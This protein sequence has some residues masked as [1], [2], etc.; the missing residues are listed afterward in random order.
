MDIRK[1]NG[2]KDKGHTRLEQV[3]LIA[4]P[5]RAKGGHKF[6]AQRL[7]IEIKKNKENK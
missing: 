2:Y 1:L 5:R 3:E 4:K 7:F 6:T